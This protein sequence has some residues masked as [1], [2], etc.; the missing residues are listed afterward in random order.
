M[1][2]LVI[3]VSAMHEETK[4]FC[5]DYL[6]EE[7]P[8]VIDIEVCVT[9]EDLL[10]EK[11]IYKDKV[12]SDTYLEQLVLFR[13]IARRIVKFHRLFFHSS[14]IAVDG[15]VYLFAAPSGTGKS[16]HT[17][18]WRK[19]F[20]NRAIMVNDDMPFLHCEEKGNIMV[21]G[22]PWNGK[23]H[24]SNNVV[25]PLKGI[26]ILT[27]AEENRI[28]RVSPE[29]AFRRMYLQTYHVRTNT[30]HMRDTME[31]IGRILECPVWHLECNISE[32]A[33]RLSYETMSGNNWD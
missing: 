28:Y 6:L 12:S 9:E 5:K 2:E 23:H 24:I 18:I 21:Y 8:N 22:S 4:E 1:A 3:A 11:E 25:L 15:E 10:Q 17:R 13:L 14:A 26:C 31:C 20:G 19:H 30:E 32:E 7:V 33:A 27:Q 16:T 29:D